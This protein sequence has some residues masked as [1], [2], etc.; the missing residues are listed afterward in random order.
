MR[1][2]TS[3]T[4]SRHISSASLD[5]YRYIIQKDVDIPLTPDP[6]NAVLFKMVVQSPKVVCD[7]CPDDVDLTL[8]QVLYDNREQGLKS[9]L[10]FRCAGPQAATIS[11][12]S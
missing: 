11:V 8:Q 2:L 9:L 7:T 1:P 5:P 3:A 10:F 4:S 12:R 6:G